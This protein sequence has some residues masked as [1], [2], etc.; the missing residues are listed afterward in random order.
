MHEK[1]DLDRMLESSLSSYGD[2]GAEQGLAERI[3]A[4]VASEQ[5]STGAG[6]GMAQPRPPLG[7]SSGSGLFAF[8]SSLI[9]VSGAAGDSPVNSSAECRVGDAHKR[10]SR[11][12]HRTGRRC[13]RVRLT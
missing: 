1:D 8:D 9:E 12:L 4:R 11:N 13:R 2:A 10:S 7:G 6:A 3:L 5:R